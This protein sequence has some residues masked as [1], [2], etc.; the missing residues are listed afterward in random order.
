M[1]LGT[2]G[3]AAGPHLTCQKFHEAVLFSPSYRQGRGSSERSGDPQEVADP[4]FES[5]HQSPVLTPSP[6]ASLHSLR[7]GAGP[8]R[9]QGWTETCS[10]ESLA[11][12]LFQPHR[13]LLARGP[14][15]G[16]PSHIVTRSRRRPGSS[17]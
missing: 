13:K 1:A 9:Q 8:E 6:T 4:E 5:G 3:F 11:T 12:S 17:Y 14:R 16:L 7:V 15:V 2:G 10:A